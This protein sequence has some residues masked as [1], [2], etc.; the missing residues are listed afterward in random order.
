[1]VRLVHVSGSNDSARVWIVFRVDGCATRSTNASA[2]HISNNNM[3]NCMQ[4]I[5]II[6]HKGIDPV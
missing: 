4:N 5:V 6:H 1:M 2:V 3:R